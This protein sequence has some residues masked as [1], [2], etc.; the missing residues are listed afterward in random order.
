MRGPYIETFPGPPP[1]SRGACSGPLVL[2]VA[3][4]PEMPA[5][6]LR[7]E[8]GP[9]EVGLGS[10]FRALLS[11]ADLHVVRRL[12]SWRIDSVLNLHLPKGRGT[13]ELLSLSLEKAEKEKG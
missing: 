8:S 6:G 13:K 12:P 2:L 3:E 7:T 11:A 4:P 1:G 9:I 10:S 5:L